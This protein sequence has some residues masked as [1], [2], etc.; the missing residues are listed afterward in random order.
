MIIL[1]ASNFDAGV[2]S[3]AFFK[4]IKLLQI[5]HAHHNRVRGAVVALLNN[6]N[7]LLGTQII[8]ITLNL[9]L[10]FNT[11]IYLFVLVHV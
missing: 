5:G 11:E 2:F 3:N 9:L 8:G 4:S 10:E 6:L 7:P 1:N